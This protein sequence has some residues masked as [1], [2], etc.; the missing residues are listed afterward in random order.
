VTRIGYERNEDRRN[1]EKF[2]GQTKIGE[3]LFEVIY[4]Y[5]LNLV[6]RIILSFTLTFVPLRNSTA[7][8]ISNQ[9]GLLRIE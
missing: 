4:F 9:T 2:L 8:K 1:S 3:R 6:V 7:V 5:F